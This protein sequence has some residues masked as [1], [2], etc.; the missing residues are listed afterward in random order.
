MKAGRHLLSLIND[1]LDISSIEA[2][3]TQLSIEPLDMGEVLGEVHGLAAPIVA[4]AGLKFEQDAPAKKLVA[5]ADRRRVIQ[6][7]L[8]LIANAAKYHG[9]GTCVR[10]KCRSDGAAIRIEV[11]DDGDGVDPAAVS[12]LFTPFDRLGQQNRT[13]LEG[14]GLGLALSQKLVESM[15]GAIGYAAPAKGARFWFTIPALAR[16]RPAAENPAEIPAEIGP[17]SIMDP[18]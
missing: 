18:A 17:P 7:M 16:P 9:S 14:T 12:R 15:G 11:E 6:V 4:S 2:G 3:G 5:H 8:N 10:L 13:R 1:L